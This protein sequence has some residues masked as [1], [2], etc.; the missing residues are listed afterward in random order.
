MYSEKHAGGP[1]LA[2]CQVKYQESSVRFENPAYL[3]PI[4][5][6]CNFCNELSAV[7]QLIYKR[8]A[9]NTDNVLT[10]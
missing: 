7:P 2:L 4:E 9:A 10:V 6:K 3:Q 1:G 5:N 8:F